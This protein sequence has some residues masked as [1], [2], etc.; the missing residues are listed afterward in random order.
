MEISTNTILDVF[1]SFQ[2]F[3][4]VGVL[5][6]LLTSL[7]IKNSASVKGSLKRLAVLSVIRPVAYAV[8][9]PTQSHHGMQEADIGKMFGIVFLASLWGG[10]LGYVII[11]SIRS[12]FQKRKETL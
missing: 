9:V 12:A 7:Q 10:C 6:T 8:L 11:T 3:L 5:T 4:V 2:P 1:E